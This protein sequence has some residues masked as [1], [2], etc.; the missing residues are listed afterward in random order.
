MPCHLSVGALFHSVTDALHVCDVT[1]IKLRFGRPS[2]AYTVPLQV[3]G[4][5]YDASDVELLHSIHHA[6]CGSLT[7]ERYRVTANVGV[8]PSGVGHAFQF[9]DDLV[10]YLLQVPWLGFTH[11]KVLQAGVLVD[12]CKKTANAAHCR[13][14]VSLGFHDCIPLLE[15]FSVLFYIVCISGF[16]ILHSASRQLP[17][18][19][20]SLLGPV[21]NAYGKTA[22]GQGHKD[23][24]TVLDVHP[25]L[26]VQVESPEITVY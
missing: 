20:L 6:E 19:C 14:G 8:M 12:I 5:G 11:G 9:L 7:T 15:V 25:L 10:M 26:S 2:G 17:V 23:D 16:S 21:G 4:S 3:G 1:L 13:L 22:P 24:S 18:W